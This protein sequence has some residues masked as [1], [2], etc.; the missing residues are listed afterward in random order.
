MVDVW[1]SGYGQQCLP[2]PF[3]TLEI[4]KLVICMKA[5]S[6]RSSRLTG[7]PTTTD[8]CV[9]IDIRMSIQNTFIKKIN[10]FHTGTTCSDAVLGWLIFNITATAKRIYW[11]QVRVAMNHAV[12]AMGYGLVQQ[13][14]GM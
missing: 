5:L 11:M 12:D 14:C 13:A 6:T 4:L 3:C 10:A 7:V 8:K 1:V 2:G 9:Y